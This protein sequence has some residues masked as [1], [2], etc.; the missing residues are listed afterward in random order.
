MS[1]VI[2]SMA[3]KIKRVGVPQRPLKSLQRDEVRTEI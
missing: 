1:D 3:S 2:S